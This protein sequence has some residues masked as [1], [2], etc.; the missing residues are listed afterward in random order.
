MKT[1]CEIEDLGSAG[2]VFPK[3]RITGVRV[4]KLAGKL[5]Q[6]FGWSLNWTNQREATLV[7]VS[8]DCGLTGWGDGAYGGELLR[9]DP[10]LVIG[11]S[12]F[13]VEA[14]FDDLRRPPQHQQRMGQPFC[15]GL[16]VALWDI[17]G[18]AVGQPV[19]GLLGRQYRTRVQP[20]CTALYRKDWPDLAAGLAEEALCWKAR[21]FRAMK[22]KAGYGPDVDVRIVRAVRNAIGDEIGLAVDANCAY[23]VGTAIA[24]GCRLEQFDLLWWEEPIL[25]EDLDGYAR[26][27]SVLRIPLASGETFGVDQLMYDYV[28]RRLVDIVQPEIEIVGLTGARRIAHLCWLNGVRMIPH[29]WGTAVRTASLLHLLATL[30]PLTESLEPPPVLFEFDCTESPFRS[31]IVKQCIDIEE[32]G[33]ISVPSRPGLGI[34]VVREA[35]DEYRTELVTVG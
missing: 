15:G 27:R 1:I 17:I 16:D 20:Y 21:G 5:K 13:E 12:P 4:H 22:M 34:D 24:L 10:R 19:S 9:R 28:Q 6:R 2:T 23:D 35:V 14:I 8:T 11:R 3:M 31:T 25:A 32:D 33:Y 7:E 26:L 18:Q 30:A 29:H